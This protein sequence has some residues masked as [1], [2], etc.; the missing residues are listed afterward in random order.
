MTAKAIRAPLAKAGRVALSITL[1]IATCLPAMAAA[2]QAAYAKARETVHM[3]HH[4]KYENVHYDSW[5]THVMMDEETGNSILCVNPSKAMASEGDYTKHYDFENYMAEN[6]GGDVSKW[7]KYL[8]RALEY[9]CNPDSPGAKTE[10]GKSIW[11]DEYF[12]G[13]ANF[14]RAEKLSTLH[15]ALAMTMNGS[16]WRDGTSSK[17]QNW[18]EKWISG[19]YGFTDGSDYHRN[20]VIGRLGNFASGS[21][22]PDWSED[23]PYL[24]NLPG[25]LD[26][27]GAFRVYVIETASN[28]Q[29]YVGFDYSDVTVALAKD[30]GGDSGLDGNPMY[31]VEGA[32]FA[33]YDN[34]DD[35][36]A[37]NAKAAEGKGFSSAAKAKS[38]AAETKADAVL[39]TGAKG[40]DKASGLARG[41]YW[42][43]EL[44]APAGCQRYGKAIK[45]NTARTDPDGELYSE[46]NPYRISVE[47]APQ[48][49]RI[50]ILLEK[51]G[52]T[53]EPAQADGDASLA[54]AVFR[55]EYFASAANSDGTP[56]AS[57]P[58][59]TWHFASGADG[60]VAT[61]APAS[62]Y[63]SDALYA[64]ASGKPAFPIGTYKVTEV[65]APE[66]Y[67]PSGKPQYVSIA[68]G[69]DQN[70]A[71]AA[72]PVR[73]GNHSTAS[74]GESAFSDLP[75]RGG[76]TVGKGD[77]AGYD[78]NLTGGDGEFYGYAQGDATFAGAEYTIYNRSAN[79]VWD[80]L[81]GDGKIGS[82]ELF[83]P[84]DAIRTI[85][86][87]YDEELDAYVAKTK[88]RELPYGTYEVVET[89][90]PE[91]H[92]N[93]GEVSRTVE[94]REDGQ[95]DRLVRSDGILNDVIRGGVQVRKD[96]LELGKS[97]ALGGAGHSS[98][99]DDGYQGTSLAGIEF[100][101]RN[102]SEHGIL[103]GDSWYHVG[104]VVATMTTHW[105]EEAQ[106]YTA[107][108]PSDALPYGTY[109]VAET[110][111]NDS[112]LL[113][114]GKPRTFQIREDGK[115]VDASRSGEA[116]TWR[117]QVVRH[118]MHLQK[119]AESGSG[120][121]AHVPF[122]VTNVTT[123]EAH[124][125]VT[126]RNGQ[127]NT[128][129][130]WRRHTENT[131]ANDALMDAESISSADVIEDAGVWFGLG[132]HGSTAEPDDGL[133]ALPFGVYRI[134]EMR[135]EA[136]EGLE[137]WSD[138][139]D[140][141][142]DTTVTGFDV[143]LGT[144]DDEEEPSVE[145]EA[146]DA[147]DGD[148]YIQASEKATVTDTV[149]YS[150]LKTGKEY[151]VTGTLMVKSTGKP[152]ED[153]EGNPITASTTFKARAPYGTVE[154]SFEFDASLLGGEK[155]VAF[156]RLEQDG[157]EV[158]SH[159]D[160]D[161]DDQTVQVVEIGTEAAD[162]E[163]GDKL[164]TGDVAT[165]VDTVSFKGL[166][167]GDSYTVTG[168]LV[169][170]ET[171]LPLADA[172]GNEIGVSAEFAAEASEGSVEVA[173]EAAVA[174]LGGHDV[175]AFERLHDA[176]GELLASHEDPDDEGQTVRVAQ[177]GT[178]LADPEDGDHYAEAGKAKLADTIEYRGL[179]PGQAY[180]VTG[181]LVDKGTG[182]A[183]EGAE[184]TAE[185]TPETADGTI[186]V[187]FELDTSDLAGRPLVAFE[188]L[189]DIDGKL[190]AKHEDLDDEGQ[191]VRVV[192]IGTVLADAAD[193]D[194][195]VEA[196]KVTLTDSVGY[197][198]LVPGE[199]CTVAGTLVDKAT[200]EPV[201]D[202]SGNDVTAAA[203]F[204]PEEGSGT[205][206]VT[207]E[208]DASALGGGRSMVAFEKLLSAE[209]NVI[210]AH[211][212]PEDE[213]QT[214]TV[215][216]IGTVLAD[217]EDG[218]HYVEAGKVRLIDTVEYAGLEPGR[219]YTMEG[220]LMDKAS[221]QPVKDASD[222]EVTASAEFTPNEP[223]GSVEVTFEFDASALGGGTSMVAFEKCLD[224]EGNLVAS[225][226][227][228]G[229]T[230]QTVNVAEIATVLVDAADG[231][232]SV[233][234]G[235]AKLTDTVEYK[236][237]VPGETYRLEGTLMDKATGEPVRDA[238][239]NEVKTAS[240]FSPGG[241]S[242]KTE[243]TFEFDASKL[244]TGTS[245]VAFEKLY[246]TEGNLVASHEDIDDEDQTVST[247]KPESPGNPGNPSSPSNPAT[248]SASTTPS[249]QT[250]SRPTPSGKYGKTG[251]QLAP[252]AIA[253]AALA[254]VGAGAAAIGIHRRRGGK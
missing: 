107:E 162:A 59:R 170:K 103:A 52:D 236:G 104:D 172:E 217:S 249:T 188:K 10:L 181:T 108:L 72:E 28:V 15:V 51:V 230:D 5:H 14:S 194:H 41:K 203:E 90:A 173:F 1:A 84:G 197:E 241:A 88:A 238:S 164:V 76:F 115:V 169:D 244:A 8:V 67:L 16:G 156:E 18:V 211:E 239:G 34:A 78:S 198:G 165:I 157:I 86:T 152:L 214:V 144:V 94:I 126:D 171:G 11:P 154:L 129:S 226:E 64:D 57:E 97:E 117:D 184:A 56:K 130:G 92:L 45:A 234:P 141:S 153:A 183:I 128:S 232:H 105:N 174:D 113:T 119:K 177:I 74:D 87:A 242:G 75:K 180:V 216:S 62:G 9:Y 161:D 24:A 7:R 111:T 176:E 95:Y 116:L 13:S 3:V 146:A 91:G 68:E 58:E 159:C 240:E 118:D 21:N 25:G 224:A 137:L 29:N 131:N 114:D 77:I 30:V 143:D 210:A 109:T 215:V 96:D 82:G 20:S 26:N 61:S 191:T 73:F 6:S 135:C 195:S 2:P 205:V 248:P 53:G 40:R 158:A 251:A 120:K 50:P 32:V 151:T 196:G 47:D 99:S 218:D 22:K 122:K 71:S 81:D 55:V 220:A 221:G 163:D 208:F 149:Y 200:G 207:F 229:D 39:V 63:R 12:D 201:R 106:A 254:A 245:A 166:N 80:D 125:V 231:D 31:S 250:A 237:L 192:R 70:S 204:V 228:P 132:E 175:V 49:Y 193:G 83:Q 100:T 227:D 27:D 42:V 102:A 139:F 225:H 69:A 134:E 33:V 60:K 66:G 212:D 136:N 182:E 222:A 142:R 213:D 98:L 37:A 187:T 44:Y 93:T 168:T 233:A 19:G 85:E 253:A 127:L 54:G 35:A 150:N 167:P 17:F 186:E 147:S 46:D 145:T 138:E 189:Y 110:A 185:F 179:T 89:K 206:E 133:G 219:A 209:G 36:D 246:G 202:A 160:I 101:V 48:M 124:V 252:L 123:G 155:L 235:P 112:Y 223:S 38:Y 4:E 178:T 247:Q 148:G 79:Q 190:I 23:N 43:V 140:V 243:V 121:L 199:A 65:E